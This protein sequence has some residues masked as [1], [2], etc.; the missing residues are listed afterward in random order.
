M[1]RST[2]AKVKKIIADLR[3]SPR[4]R[5]LAGANG[6]KIFAVWVDHMMTRSRH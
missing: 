1:S 4:D 3:G 2:R 6:K 5:L